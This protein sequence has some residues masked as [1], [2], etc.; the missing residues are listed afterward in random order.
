M[1]RNGT[2]PKPLKKG[3]VTPVHKAKSKLQWSNYRPISVLSCLANVMETLITKQMQPHLEVIYSPHLSAYRQDYGCHS[4]LMY[5][6]EMWR[7]ALDDKKYVGILMSDL[8][9]AFDCLPHNLL[10]EKLRHYKFS[11]S[12]IQ[13]LGNYLSD[14][15]QRVKIGQTMSAWEPLKKGVPQGSVLGP[16]CFNLYI[17]DLLLSLVRNN[18]IPSN[19]ADDN[20]SS[21]V[22]TTKSEVLQKV[23]DTFKILTS[24]FNDNQMKANVEKFQFM[25][26]C[27]L[28]EENKLSHTIQIDNLTLRSQDE[29]K[30]LG[31]Y[32]DKE[33]T[34]N[35]HV[36]VKCKQ[37][38]SKLS[39]LTR[40]TSYLSEDCKLAV[41]RNFIVSHFIYC[42]P[43][44][45]FCTKYHKNKMEKI[46]LRGLR[47]VFEDYKI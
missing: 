20:S 32:I 10:I 4:V 22:A 6:T 35:N 34:M 7:H 29:A 23:K 36:K 24:W 13:L 38:N 25:L 28:V 44:L 40:L 19:Y 21:V 43:L 47:F 17:N 46:L 3:E 41:L 12:A 15:S 26:L 16:Q 11:D 18:I 8:S 45:H 27:P 33:L 5:S 39:V 42:S 37:A 1:L 14:R 31:V 30:L 9:K 2:F